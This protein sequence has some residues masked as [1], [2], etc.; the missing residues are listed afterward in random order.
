MTNEPTKQT[1][2]L[3]AECCLQSYRYAKG[4]KDI[5]IPPSYELIA[6]IHT[7]SKEPFGLVL[8][9]K[10]AVIIAFR[11]T[12]S[13]ENLIKDM[14]IQQILYPLCENA[15]NVHSG[16]LSIYTEIRPSLLY[17]LSSLPKTKPLII[18][19]HSLGGALAILAALDVKV[20][21]PFEQVIMCNFGAPKVGDKPF[22]TTYNKHLLNS[23]RVINLF[24]G[25]PLFPPSKKLMESLLNE[26]L[27]YVHVEK[28]VIL[29][30]Y[31]KSL[32]DA[33]NLQTYIVAL[34]KWK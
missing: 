15:G 11:G 12:Q 29:S 13:Q 17:Y 2:L 32:T 3:L 16:F 27:E 23:Y 10:E 7:P 22:V 28:V 8:E 1:L 26:K 31:E 25:I 14:E 4:E 24:D 21:T 30:K 19:G 18:T 9:S 20:N 34:Q 5:I 6:P 33:H